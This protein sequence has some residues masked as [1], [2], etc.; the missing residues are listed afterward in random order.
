MR[1]LIVGLGNMGPAYT[2]TR[3]NIGF[4]IL[5]ALAEDFD[6]PFQD[7]RYG[8]IAR[9]GVKG[10]SFI[11]LKPGTFVN[12]SGRAV[13]YWLKKEDVPLENMLVVLDDLSLPFGVLRMKPRGGDGGHNGLAHINQ[14]LGTQNYARMRFG[15]SDE[16]MRGAQVSYVLGE[17]TPEEQ[18]ALPRRISI[19]CDMIISFGLAGTENTMNK[20]NNR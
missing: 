7:K 20:Y 13:H 5:D 15:I 2:Q 8:F 9:L 1:F 12:L 3:H 14:I 16:Y 18:A 6:A 10:R 4:M 17:W 11:L 19:A